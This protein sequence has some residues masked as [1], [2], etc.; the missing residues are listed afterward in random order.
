MTLSLNHLR[1]FLQVATIH[2]C[3]RGYP[4]YER[5]SSRSIDPRIVWDRLAPVWL[6]GRGADGVKEHVLVQSKIGCEFAL[7]KVSHMMNDV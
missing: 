6:V 2:P 1:V 4:P 7:L 5:N 3:H